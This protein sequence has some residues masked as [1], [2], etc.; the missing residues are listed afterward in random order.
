MCRYEPFVDDVPG[1]I[2]DA[3]YTAQTTLSGILAMVMARV[4]PIAINHTMFVNPFATNA[5]KTAQIHSCQ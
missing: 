1:L 2:L 4:K 3:E 5:G